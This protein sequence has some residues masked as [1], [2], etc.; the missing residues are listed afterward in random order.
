MFWIFIQPYDFWLPYSFYWFGKFF[1]YF[2]K[3]CPSR[4]CIIATCL[5]SAP[6]EGLLVDLDA[7]SL[8]KIAA[9]NHSVV[10]RYQNGSEV[11]R[12][13]TQ[14]QP[15]IPLIQLA[16]R[17]T[18]NDQHEKLQR[19]MLQRQPNGT[20]Y[21]IKRRTHHS[22]KAARL[23]HQPQPVQFSLSSPLEKSS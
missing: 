4:F 19:T 1:G 15:R 14:A 9:I 20:S 18:V 10:V 16:A 13:G 12:F 17:K 6:G 7:E 8:K 23:N 21:K 11:A 22:K 5:P 2:L 3:R